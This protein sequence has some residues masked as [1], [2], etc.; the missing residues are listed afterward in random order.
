MWDLSQNNKTQEGVMLV[1]RKCLSSW[2]LFVRKG[3]WI[4]SH[5]FLFGLFILLYVHG[6]HVMRLHVCFLDL[7]KIYGFKWTSY[8][9]NQSFFGEK[10]HYLVILFLNEKNEKIV[11]FRDLFCQFLK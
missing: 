8:P 5:I 7:S 2:P 1:N 10:F 3:H 9:S 4:R 11:I 6:W